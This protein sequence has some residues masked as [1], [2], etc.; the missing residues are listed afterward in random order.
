MGGRRAADYLIHMQAR[1]A[2]LRPAL[3][4]QWI[5]NPVQVNAENNIL[6]QYFTRFF[7]RHFFVSLGA[8]SNNNL[9]RAF[10]FYCTIWQQQQIKAQDC[11]FIS[12]PTRVKQK[13]AHTNTCTVYIILSRQNLRNIAI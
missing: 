12:K 3:V 10:Y 11:L 2:K 13:Q 7:V 8:C 9:S 4:P 1:H 6:L 5:G